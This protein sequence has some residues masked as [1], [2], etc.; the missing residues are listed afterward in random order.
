MISI[1]LKILFW[2]L[3]T[4]L[5]IFFILLFYPVL[6][7]G[8]ITAKS[9]SFDGICSSLRIRLVSVLVILVLKKQE[10][11]IEIY[12][13]ILGIKI[14]LDEKDKA[15]KKNLK[16]ENLKN[17]ASLRKKTEKSDEG[18]STDEIKADFATESNEENMK[19][20]EPV[21]FGFAKKVKEKID[22]LIRFFKRIKEKKEKYIKLYETESFKRA[23][24]KLKSVFPKL[25]KHIAPRKVKGNI[26]VGFEQCDSTGKFFG[27]YSV[28]CSYFTY[29]LKVIP[30]FE[31]EVFEGKMNFKG[32]IFPVY[33]IW[34]GLNF[35]LNRD[36]NLTYKRFKKIN[37]R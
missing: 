17:R 10:E 20:K 34:H 1:I 16:Y 35:F 33:L 13:R 37:R 11:K 8:K 5:S 21:F 25:M 12:L 18:S 26:Q 30:D 3:I 23:F 2:I 36:V 15:D 31:H 19:E 4:V 9:L 6:Y 22:S 24:S 7:R 29:D 14:R 27:Y 32:R 28:I